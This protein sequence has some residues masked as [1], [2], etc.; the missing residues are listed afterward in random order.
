MPSSLQH[1]EAFT[2]KLS[3]LVDN[4]SS[5]EG[6]ERVD[7]DEMDK[8]RAS[9]Q[10]FHHTA[11]CG[12]PYRIGGVDGSG[13]FPSF[14]YSD[15]FVYIASASG[16]VY[17]TDSFRGLSEMGS[18]AD[19]NLE[20]VWLPEDREAARPLWIDAL[21]QLAGESVKEVITR[22]DYKELKSATSHHGH[23]V[24]QL[25]NHLIL[26]AASDTAN[27]G[28]QLRS[29][30]ELGAAL[31]LIRHQAN[32]SYVLMDTTM[33]LPMVTRKDLSLFYEHLKRLC[34]V[35]ALT[36][37]VVYMTVSKSH[38]LPCIDLI[39][40]IAAQAA[41]DA[42]KIA[43]HW[44]WRLPIAGVEDWEF[45]LV[46]HRMIPPVGAVT[47]QVRFHRNTPVLRF[48][49]DRTYWEMH[50]QDNPT[51]EQKI[52]SELDYSG[53]DQRA[54]GYPYPIKACHD[55]VRLS[56]AERTALKKQ[57]IEAAV[58]KGMKR[59]LF[60]DVSSSTGHV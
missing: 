33:G 4:M 8:I 9:I 25:L 29:T 27:V 43:E 37:G 15:S 58:A 12:A 38:G 57:I 54:Y 26:P 55:R 34:C 21:S 30:A 60:K 2:S 32:C 48:D 10:Q 50:L 6:K 41:G 23:T 11:S 28:I 24:E 20:L 17:E 47:Y 44:F 31:R 56:M 45:S 5:W 42:G 16:T 40:Q 52:F 49:I 14:S 7:K 36:K 3:T 53:H 1:R 22:S 39:E 59:S 19:P 13:D 46:E 51:A 18:V 35:E